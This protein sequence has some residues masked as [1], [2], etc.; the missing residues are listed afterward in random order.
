MGNSESKA[1]FS[2][3]VAKVADEIDELKSLLED[4]RKAPQFMFNF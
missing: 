4:V 2:E 1:F 3:N